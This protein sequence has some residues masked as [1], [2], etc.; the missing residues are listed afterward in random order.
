MLNL[1]DSYVG[2]IPLLIVGITELVVVIYLYGAGYETEDTEKCPWRLMR[3]SLSF[4][5][6]AIKRLSRDRF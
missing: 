6:Q 2:G 3:G 4:F 5:L 1:I